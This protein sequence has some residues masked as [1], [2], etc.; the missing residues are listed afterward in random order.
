VTCTDIARIFRKI[1]SVPFKLK[2]FSFTELL[3]SEAAEGLE[4]RLCVGQ[5]NVIREIKLV[6]R[7]D[8]WLV[9]AVLLELREIQAKYTH[10]HRWGTCEFLRG[11]V[12]DL[13]GE[14]LYMDGKGEVDAALLTEG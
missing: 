7:E 3:P 4:K 5:R 6:C 11:D 13:F 12:E 14:Q 10:K 2:V 8:W 9:L 1:Y